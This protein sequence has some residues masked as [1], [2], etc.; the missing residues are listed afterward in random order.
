MRHVVV[1]AHQQL[2]G[3][4][5]RRQLDARLGLAAAEVEMVPVVGISSSKAGRGALMMTWW[6]PV[7]AF[8]VLAG[9]TP[10]FFRPMRS[11]NLPPGMV[12]PS[13]GQMM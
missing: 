7:L 13:L 3:V 1:V 10:K 12:R 8:S 11:Q 4:P 2:D 5:P 6:W 9:A